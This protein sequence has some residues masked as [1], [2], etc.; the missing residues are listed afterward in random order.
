MMHRTLTQ[1]IS[2]LYSEKELN[3]H[4]YT[5]VHTHTHTHTHEH[6]HTHRGSIIW[7][8][9]CC[10]QLRSVLAVRTNTLS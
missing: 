3:T 8:V 9:F 1:N 5:H 4:V 10:W 6:T 2:G 7:T